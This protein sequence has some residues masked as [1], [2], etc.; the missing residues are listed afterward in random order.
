MEIFNYHEKDL[1]GLYG[2]FEIYTSFADIMQL[3][4]N[5]W[6]NTDET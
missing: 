2:K 5:K 6:R 1:E 3:E 4:Y